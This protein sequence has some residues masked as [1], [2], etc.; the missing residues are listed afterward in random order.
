VKQHNNFTSLIL[1]MAVTCLIVAAVSMISLYRTAIDQ[2]RLR[3]TETV[4]SQARL[5]EAIASFNAF[6]DGNNIPDDWQELTLQ[7]IKTAHSQFEGFGD[8]GEYAMA[9]RSNSKIEFVLSHRHFDLNTPTPIPF[10]GNWAEPMRLALTGKS[11]TV[12]ALD[13][14][15]VPVLAAHEPINLL[16]L[17]LVAK[18]DLAE[19]RAP[20]IRAGLIALGVGTLI[21][22]LSSRLFFRVTQPIAQHIEQQA[23]TFRTLAETSREGIILIDTAARIEYCNPSAETMFGY[24]TGELIGGSL[25]RLMPKSVSRQHDQYI[26]NY[27][28]TGVGQIIGK[29]RQLIG[30]RKD[31]TQF[32]MYL[33]IGDIKLEHTRLFAGVI[34]DISEQLRL[35]REIMEVPI[36]EQ[37]RIGQELHDGIGQQLTGL[38]MLATSLLNKATRPEHNLASQ[39]ATGLQDTLTQVRA[40]SHGL[41][42]VEID[43]EGF[44]SALKNLTEEIQRQSHIPVSFEIHDEIRF[45]NNDTVMHLYRIAQE[46]LNNAIKHSN[47]SH[48]KV[49]L[50]VEDDDGLLE[51]YDNGRGINDDVS[52]DDGLGLSIM[53]YRSSLFEGEIKILPVADGGTRI[54]CR[55]PLK[56]AGAEN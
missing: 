49:S 37:R 6:K 27:L 16:N 10:E 22:L 55:F 52:N 29:G 43:A 11:G 7:Q 53:K 47:S 19:I 40:L 33:S 35:Q 30:L 3:L 8:S 45:S 26:E 15:G 42:P 44:T 56:Q 18:I 23:E 14:R 50:E 39:L 2:H 48:M 5:I 21:V 25:N 51:I 54:C 17:G 1:I 13:Y 46:A 24:Q 9:R 41:V 38:G 20:F 31:G 12:I 36:R 28:K 34:M 32:P 4:K